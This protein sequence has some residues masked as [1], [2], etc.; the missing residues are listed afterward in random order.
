MFITLLGHQTVL[1]TKVN[2]SIYFNNFL[3]I[4]HILGLAL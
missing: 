3:N 4:H 1:Y 2:I